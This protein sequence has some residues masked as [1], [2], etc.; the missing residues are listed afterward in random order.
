M[1]TKRVRHADPEEGL[2]FTAESADA[3]VDVGLTLTH[4]G[5]IITG[6]DPGE[7]DQGQADWRQDVLAVP[8]PG[9]LVREQTLREIGGLDPE[10][11]TPW[12]EI[13]LCRRI[14][15]SGERVAVQASSRVLHPYPTRPLLE[16]L[17]EQRTG[18]LLALLKHRTLPHALLTLVLLL[19]LATILR[20]LGAIAATAPAQL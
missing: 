14:W 13:D 7:I 11:P 4:G 3:L 10:L 1:G 8:L 18:Q 17:Q 9:M 15:R 12:A 19:P 2:P 16:R 5:R 20:M 6:V